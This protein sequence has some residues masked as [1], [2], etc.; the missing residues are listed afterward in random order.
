VALLVVAGALYLLWPQPTDA[1][2]ARL[3]G[4][5]VGAVFIVFAS[6]LWIS[7][8]PTGLAPQGFTVALLFTDLRKNRFRTRFVWSEVARVHFLYRDGAPIVA[9]VTTKRGHEIA[10][11][12]EP[13][14]ITR[15]PEI[16]RLFEAEC[17]KRMIPSTREDQDLNEVRRLMRH[18][19]REFWGLTS[20][21]EEIP[22]EPPK[23]P[24]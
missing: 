8:I 15:G 12:F 11:N 6:M 4:I 13:A 5:P 16:G 20:R 7:G 2:E 19:K 21:I 18:A 3:I 14:R 24:A 9:S 23:D 10:L 1:A 17:A 22:I